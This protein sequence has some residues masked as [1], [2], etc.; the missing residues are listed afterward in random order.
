[1]RGD[2]EYFSRR[3]TQ[4]REAAIRASNAQARRLHL[5]MADLYAGLVKSSGDRR[6]LPSLDFFDVA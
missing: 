5:D 3:M 1:M 6:Q 2:F 4:E